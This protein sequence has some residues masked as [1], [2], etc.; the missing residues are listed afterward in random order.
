MKRLI[1]RTEPNRP[2]I[3]SVISNVKEHETQ[4]K[5]DALKPSARPACN[6]SVFYLPPR[7]QTSTLQRPSNPSG[8]PAVHPCAAGEGLSRV[9]RSDP[10]VQKQM[11]LKKTVIKV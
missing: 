11:N 6:T 9:T 8:A 7:P 4:T 10:Q 3:S 1:H 5:Q 2:H